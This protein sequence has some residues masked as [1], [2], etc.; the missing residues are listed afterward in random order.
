MS[1]RG[2][3]NFCDPAGRE[4]KGHGEEMYWKSRSVIDWNNGGKEKIC[5]GKH[6]L[7]EYPARQRR[8]PPGAATEKELA[9]VLNISGDQTLIAW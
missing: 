8:L 5:S 3:Q 2:A 1:G 6:F 7:T 4:Q 9:A